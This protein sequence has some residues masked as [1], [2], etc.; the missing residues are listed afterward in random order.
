MLVKCL[1]SSAYTQLVGTISQLM[2]LEV[3]YLQ[4]PFAVPGAIQLFLPICSLHT[5]IKEVV[6]KDKSL[7]LPAPGRSP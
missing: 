5:S 1:K 3:V 2:M 6:F 4:S 7:A